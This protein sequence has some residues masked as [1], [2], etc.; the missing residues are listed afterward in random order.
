MIIIILVSVSSRSYIL[1]YINGNNLT[2][3]DFISFRLL[4]ELYSLLYL[5]IFIITNYNIFK[6]PS[7]L[8]VIFSLISIQQNSKGFYFYV[9]V[10]SRSYILSYAGLAGILKILNSL[11]FRLLSELYSL[12]CYF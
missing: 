3:D 6:F 12:L 11:G 7:P 2:L 9:S 8:G 4:S 1:S 10:S 5:L